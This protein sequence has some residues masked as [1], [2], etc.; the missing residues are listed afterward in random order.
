[1]KENQRQS[2]FIADKQLLNEF[3]IWSI[4]NNTTRSAE[5]VKFI[6]QCVSDSKK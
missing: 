6:Q 2:S 3:A 5:I 4:N 1:M